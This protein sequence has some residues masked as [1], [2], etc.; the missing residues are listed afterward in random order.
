[1]ML[2]RTLHGSSLLLKVIVSLVESSGPVVPKAGSADPE[3][4]VTVSLRVRGCRSIMDAL[5]FTYFFIEV[6]IL[7]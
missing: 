6:A 2:L 5:K 4:C 7:C 1:M 3:R